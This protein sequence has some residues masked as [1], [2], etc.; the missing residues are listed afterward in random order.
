MAK[1]SRKD[2]SNRERVPASIELAILEGVAD[3]IY[4]AD[5]HTHE[6]LYCNRAVEELWGAGAVGK[7]CHA[8]LQ[9][10]DAPCPFCTNQLIFGSNRGQVY[11]WEFKNERTH[12]WFRCSDRAIRW[13]DGRWVRLEVAVDITAARQDEDALQESESRFRHVIESITD[14][15]YRRNLM[16]DGYDYMSPSCERV[17]GYTSEEMLSMPLELVKGHVHPDDLDSVVRA[18]NECL[19]RASGTA[20]V[21]YRFRHRS[22]DY[23]WVSDAFSVSR[24]GLG[25][26]RYLVGSVRDITAKKR[27]EEELRQ[28]EARFRELLA[29]VPDL[30]FVVDKDGVLRDFQATSTD[31]LFAQPAEFL[32]R[33]VHEVLP[34]HVA[35]LASRAIAEVAAV[36]HAVGFEYELEQQGLVNTYEARLFPSGDDA[37]VVLVRNITEQRSGQ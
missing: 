22:G 8:V 27:A 23:R 35:E 19:T 28:S 10:R 25:R 18:V 1:V 4:V 16:R 7:K 17:F 32:G 33:N 12:R 31:T 3:V 26:A 34:P 6:L 30:F 11:V 2:C 13:P 14:V 21:E 24:D 36:G 9:A 29:A 20:R 5:P 15:A 37:Y